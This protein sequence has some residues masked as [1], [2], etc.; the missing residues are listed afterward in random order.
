ERRIKLHLI[1]IRRINAEL[2][3]KPQFI[4]DSQKGW[5][6]P[7]MWTYASSPTVPSSLAKQE[8]SYYVCHPGQNRSPKKVRQAACVLRLL[9]D[10]A[11]AADDP[12]RAGLLEQQSSASDCGSYTHD[13]QSKRL[14]RFCARRKSGPGDA[15]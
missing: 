6:R 9:C 4:D 12:Y 15:A 13:A 3:M 2:C 7:S 8:A 10:T 11:P 14:R 1:R 5:Y